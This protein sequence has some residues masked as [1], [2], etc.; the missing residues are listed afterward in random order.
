MQPCDGWWDQAGWREPR[1]IPETQLLHPSNVK[2]DLPVCVAVRRIVKVLVRKRM[3][4]G[5][6]RVGVVGKPSRD[7]V[8]FGTCQAPS[9]VHEFG[10]PKIGPCPK[11]LLEL[12]R[13]IWALVI[14]DGGVWVTDVPF[15]VP[16]GVDEHGLFYVSVSVVPHLNEVVGARG[17]S[18]G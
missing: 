8:E 9:V 2:V 10:W 3:G 5:G 4:D 15:G 17:E 16:S 11:G 18:A 12:Q 6:E 1:A 14:F 13:S 7:T